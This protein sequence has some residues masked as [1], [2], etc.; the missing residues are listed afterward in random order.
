MAP[1][2]PATA[3][4][5]TQGL[6]RS[7]EN[8]STPRRAADRHTGRPR[9]LDARHHQAHPRISSPRR[10]VRLS[11]R[12]TRR[13]RG[14]LHLYASQW[15]RWRRAP[16]SARPRRCRS[17]SAAR[18]ASRP[19]LPPSREGSGE[20][21]GKRRRNAREEHDD[22]EAGSRR[23]GV[24]PQPRAIARPQ[25]RLGEKAVREA[26][27]LPADEALAMHVV[28]FVAPDVRL[29]SRSAGTAHMRPGRT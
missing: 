1:I 25:C 4:Y 16:I 6:K 13:E 27:S 23:G 22:R 28:D 14:H 2:T 7:V 19:R 3:D 5:F 12:G 29:C 24:H 11:G 21:K 20:R 26:V 15:R 9:H 10:D 17:A 18:R 8:G